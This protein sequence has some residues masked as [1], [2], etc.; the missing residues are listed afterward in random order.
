M[1]HA[2]TIGLYH[3]DCPDG[4]AA[5]AVLL[6]KFQ[7]IELHPVG[8]DI[9]PAELDTI[10]ERVG[11][12]TEVYTVDIAVGARELLARAKSVTT[13]DH[14][15]GIKDELEQLA[16]EHAN[17]TFIFDNERSGAS[18][19]WHYFFH[20]EPVPEL[21]TLVEDNDLWRFHFRARTR[22]LLFYL[23]TLVN[24]P[25]RVLDLLASDLE[26]LIAAGEQMARLAG[27]LTEH[28]AEGREPTWLAIGPHRV[29]GYNAS[30][31]E[32]ELG[33]TLSRKHG[34][35]VA[36]FRFKGA[37]VNFSFRSTNEHSPSALELATALGGG[38]HRNASGASVPLEKFVAMLEF[39]K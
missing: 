17:F 26:P 25:K 13:I 32:S 27:Y 14:H 15:I 10:L 38:G 7:Q 21:I 35:A 29:H 33:N 36:I 19:A 20:D 11:A 6:R 39:G 28:F 23:Q 18:L 2:H 30:F 9:A 34:A 3:K 8:H 31:F 37:A 5:A 16:R 24:Q 12:E 1:H 4:T 22:H